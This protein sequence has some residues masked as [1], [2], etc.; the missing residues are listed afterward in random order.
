MTQR[1]VEVIQSICWCAF[2]C[3]LVSSC[4]AY[5]PTKTIVEYRGECK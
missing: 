2:F 4:Y 5:S 1:H 3:V